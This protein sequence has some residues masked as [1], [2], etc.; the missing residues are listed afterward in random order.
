VF[1][2]IKD[3]RKATNQ[4]MFFPIQKMHSLRLKPH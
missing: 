1:Y 4:G 3:H 2:W